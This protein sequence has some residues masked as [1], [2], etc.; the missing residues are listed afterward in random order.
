MQ[1]VSL[2][3]ITKNE[4][5]NIQRCLQSVSWASDIVVL[6][7]ESTDRTCE[8]AE[9]CGARIFREKFRGFRAQKERA[10]ELA[11]HDWVISLDADE[12][13]S[14][15]LNQEIQKLIKENQLHVDGYQIPRLSFHMG[16]WIRH[17]GWYPDYQLRFFN[18]KKCKWV[19]G[20]VHESVKGENIKKCQNP[21]HHY[22]F[23]SLTH[24]VQTNNLYS[25]Y[26]AVDLLEKKRR[27]GLHL[28][29]LKPISKFLETFLLK[30]GF[31]D[32]VE[33]FIISVGAAYSVFLK[34][35]KLR[36][37]KKGRTIE[38]SS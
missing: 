1:N 16:K 29:I 8:I 26:G 12:V 3:V 28:L 37:L 21:I 19:G 15:E 20:A 35:A 34:Y 36:E 11:K 9:R 2:V 33:G 31:M 5:L 25:S 14:L 27:F 24:Q 23:R 30:R 17:G 22:V 38:L 32:G 10:T 6:D 18:R 7:S 4:E 13:L